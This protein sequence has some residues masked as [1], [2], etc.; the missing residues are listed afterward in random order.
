M[1][2]VIKL[3]IKQ[4]FAL[5]LW[6]N[7]PNKTAHYFGYKNKPYNKALLFIKGKGNIS[8]E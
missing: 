1:F 3:F 2:E 4:L 5:F 7:N 6:E 8:S